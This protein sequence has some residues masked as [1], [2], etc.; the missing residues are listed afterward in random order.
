MLAS[1]FPQSSGNEQDCC[2]NSTAACQQDEEQ[3][4]GEATR[5]CPSHLP[6]FP[7]LIDCIKGERRRA[8]L[9]LGFDLATIDRLPR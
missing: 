2:Q 1:I 8:P 5:L 7:L 6:D 3:G 9:S 4:G